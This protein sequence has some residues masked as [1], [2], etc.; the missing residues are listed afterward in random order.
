MLLVVFFL[1]FLLIGARLINVQ[2]T[3]SAKYAAYDNSQLEHLVTIAAP[4]GEI[5]DRNGNLLATS[6]PETTVYADPHQISDPAGE[7]TQLAPVLGVPEAQLERELRENVGFVYLAREIGNHAG[8]AAKALHLAGIGFLT[9]PKRFDPNGALALPLLGLVG[10]DGTGLS[11]LEAQ[12]QGELAGRAGQMFEEEGPGGSQIPGSTQLVRAARPGTGVLLT[13]D[14]SIQYEAEAALASEIQISGA[15]AGT[16]VVLDSHSGGILAMANLEAGT[17][18]AATPREAGYNLATDAVFE[19]GSVMKVTTFAGALNEGIIDPTTMFTVP[20]QLEVGGY[21]F[22][23]AESHGTETLSATEILAQSS[24]I[25]TIEIAQKLGAARVD[26]YMRLF[27]FGEPSGLAFPGESNGILIP[28]SQWDGSTIGSDPIGQDAAVTPLQI[29]DAYNVIANGGVFVPPRLVEATMNSKG[30]RVAVAP[31]PTHRVLSSAIAG[32]LRGMLEQVVSAGTGAEA[33]VPG[34]TVAGKTGTAQIPNPK[35][36]GYLAGQFMATF[37]GFVPAQAPAL[38]IVVSL[39]DPKTSIYGGSVAAP[40]FAQIARYSLR[41]LAIPPPADVNG[42]TVTL[43]APAAPPATGSSS[44][45][46]PLSS[47]VTGG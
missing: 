10:V 6:I 22:H 40:V 15:K 44:T 28:L 33:V 8:D 42:G 4:R 36:P 31:A 21:A 29:A 1:L 13:L 23:D 43:Q 5:F 46:V 35:G 37:V 26:R 25:G 18:P 9:E 11:G 41:V 39:Q 45:T 3:S 27:G 24:N 19:P 12:L 7:A 47:D 14:T 20:P 17:A 16:V 34:Y 32:E 38:T 2:I 30:D